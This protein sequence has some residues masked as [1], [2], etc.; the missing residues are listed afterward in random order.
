MLVPVMCLVMEIVPFQALVDAV[1]VESVVIGAV[2]VVIDEVH[3]VKRQYFVVA[4][5]PRSRTSS[6]VDPMRNSTHSR[7]VD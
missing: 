2:G 4:V 6:R 3:V 7:E 1:G 5:E